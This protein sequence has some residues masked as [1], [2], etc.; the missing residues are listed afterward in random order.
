MLEVVARQ[1]SDAG[2]GRLKRMATDNHA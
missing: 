1:T 2:L